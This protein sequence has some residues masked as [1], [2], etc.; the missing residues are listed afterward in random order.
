M[1]ITLCD[2]NPNFFEHALITSLS[3]DARQA[4]VGTAREVESYVPVLDS[5]IPF[6][7]CPT[8]S[9]VAT[10]SIC[11]IVCTSSESSFS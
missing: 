1:I 3:L 11:G 2:S 7:H 9:S 6:Q 10:M 8:K 4:Q 5:A